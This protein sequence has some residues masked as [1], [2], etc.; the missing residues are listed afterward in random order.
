MEKQAD[1]RHLHGLEMLLVLGGDI[2][3]VLRAIRRNLLMQL[4]R[5][6][7]VAHDAKGQKQQNDDK[8]AEQ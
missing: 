6:K 7:R 4:P 8:K 3:Q 2:G 5:K 1:K